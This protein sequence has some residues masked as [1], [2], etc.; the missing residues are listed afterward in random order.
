MARRTRKFLLDNTTGTAY[1]NI[2]NVTGAPLSSVAAGIKPKTSRIALSAAGRPVVKLTGNKAVFTRAANLISQIYLEVTDA[3]GA[4]TAIAAPAGGS[5]D[6]NLR[7][8]DSSNV[9]STLGTYSITSGN[10]SSTY[11]TALNILNTDTV[12]IDITGIGTIRPG[13]GLNVVITFYG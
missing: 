13:T 3:R 8:V 11:A 4:R 6:I 7:K 10:T 2:N 9:S 1:T 12:F 5:I